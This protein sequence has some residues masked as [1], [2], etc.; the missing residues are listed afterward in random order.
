MDRKARFYLPFFYF[1]T[2][3]FIFNI[4][5]SDDY[6]NSQ[7][8]I[9]DQSEG[10]FQGLGRVHITTAAWVGSILFFFGGLSL[11]LGVYVARRLFAARELLKSTEQ[12]KMSCPSARRTMCRAKTM[13]R[14]T[15]DAAWPT[16]IGHAANAPGVVIGQKRRAMVGSKS[17]A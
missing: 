14:L 12:Q 10:M 5:L 11:V 1:V 3:I 6:H 8:S 7:A 2:Q 9:A 4:E 17:Q 16:G 13:N 15:G